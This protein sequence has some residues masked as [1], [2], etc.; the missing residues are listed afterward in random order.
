MS[1]LS[2][3]KIVTVIF[4]TIEFPDNFLGFFCSRGAISM[5][6]CAVTY[7]GSQTIFLPPHLAMLAF[8]KCFFFLGGQLEII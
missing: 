8:Y 3:F 7:R 5:I 1:A 6:L 2:L 4:F